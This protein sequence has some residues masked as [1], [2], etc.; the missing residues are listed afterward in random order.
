MNFKYIYGVFAIDEENNIWKCENNAG[1]LVYSKC[2]EFT[3]DGD[4]EKVYQYV[5]N[6]NVIP[7]VL[8]KDGRAVFLNE[9]G[10]VEEVSNQAIDISSSFYILEEKQI[11]DLKND[12]IISLSDLL[13]NAEIPIKVNKEGEF[14]TD[15]LNLYAIDGKLLSS[16]V[17]KLGDYFYR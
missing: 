3:I 16:G 10:S 8:Y 9:D 17:A 14:L 5:R 15:K 6:N 7:F 1:T 4:I 12:E 2:T 13:G 11:I